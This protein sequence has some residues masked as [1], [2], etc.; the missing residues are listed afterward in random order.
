MRIRPARETDQDAIA[1][2]TQDTWEQYEGGDYINHIFPKWATQTRPDQQTFVAEADGTPIGLIRAVLLSDHEAWFQGLR[3]DPAH[4]GSGVGEALTDRAFEW[5]REA[6]ATVGR[7]MVF[8]W[9]VMGLGLTRA[10]G[11][12]SGVEFRW[13]HP[14]PD[15]A[16]EVEGTVRREPK[17]AWTYWQHA[18]ERD[19]L[20]GLGLD[21]E[22]PWALSEATLDDF[23]SARAAESVLSID[24]EGVVATTYRARVIEREAGDQSRTWAEYGLAAWEDLTAAADLFAAISRDAAMAGADRV[25]VLLPETPRVVGDAAA[26]RIELA[27]NPDFVVRVDLTG[28]TTRR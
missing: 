22:V 12:D 25:R 4:R 23:Q 7:A 3:V 10:A 24:R 5:A 2:F 15:P 16:A 27:D 8:S 26:H 11:F 13:G 21:S 6:G 18:P 20:D 17:A 9:N 1:A 19:T 14:E 28:P